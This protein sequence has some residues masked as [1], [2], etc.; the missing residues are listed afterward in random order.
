MRTIE[1]AAMGVVLLSTSTVGGGCNQY[2]RAPA[3]PAPPRAVPA[4]PVD[5]RSNGWGTEDKAVDV[6]I[7]ADVPVRISASMGVSPVV[8]CATTPCL[9]R[10][11]PGAYTLYAATPTSPERT[12][13]VLLQ[14]SARPTIV[15]LRLAPDAEWSA[16]GVTLWSPEDGK[17]YTG[18]VR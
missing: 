18:D 15:Q 17:I 12:C 5:S 9:T 7:D 13:D 6:V 14:I 10:F 16:C 2:S 3:P 1:R 4:S 11:P 8:M